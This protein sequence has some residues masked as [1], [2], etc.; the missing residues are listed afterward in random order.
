[1][2]PFARIA[3][4]IFLLLGLT[5]LA[6]GMLGR[7]GVL[8]EWGRQL[9]E[10]RSSLRQGRPSVQITDVIATVTPSPPQ[11]LAGA[12]ATRPDLTM[13][14]E[15]LVSA[16]IPAVLPKPATL[17]LPTDDAFA[18]LP[19]DALTALRNN[20]DVLQATLK[21]H[22]VRGRVPASEIV[23]FDVLPTLN[24]SSIPVAVNGTTIVGGA[25]IVEVNQPFANGLIQTIDRVLLPSNNLRQPVIDTPD[26]QTTVNFR[27]DYLTVVGSAEPFTRLLLHRNGTLFGET[28]VSADG[29]WQI[30]GNIT[31]GTHAL[32]A[33]MLN[34]NPESP[35]PLAISAEITLIVE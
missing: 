33:Y 7:R 32:V 24:G 27:G 11:P 25:S 8:A 12:L 18:S 9:S 15:L 28:T 30:G 35:H 3:G 6:V 29:R 1:M 22:I 16:E 34:G 14:Y 5:L 13:A 23:R 19:P 20:P 10:Q 21:H 2:T 31:S 4:F 17:F 26:G